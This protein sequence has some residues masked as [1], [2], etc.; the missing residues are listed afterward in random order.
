MSG[1]R[2]QPVL[3]MPNSV[4]V[5]YLYNY[6]DECTKV[7]GG[8][9]IVNGSSCT[10]SKESDH[11]N[12]V[13]ARTTTGYVPEYIHQVGVFRTAEKIT[14]DSNLYSALYLD[15]E[16]NISRWNGYQSYLRVY[17]SKDDSNYP[18]KDAIEL[19][20]IWEGPYKNQRFYR[21][22]ATDEP[23]R[24][25][26]IVFSN[27][28]T[29]QYYVYV[30]HYTDFEE[31]GTCNVYAMWF[32]DSVDPYKTYLY[33][34][35]TNYVELS[36]VILSEKTSSY[37]GYS[38][39]Y[40]TNYIDL[41]I[42]SDEYNTG[43]FTYMNDLIYGMVYANQ[44]YDITP[45]RALKMHYSIPSNEIRDHDGCKPGAT[46]GILSTIPEDA[47][48]NDKI[49][50]QNYD[51][52][53]YDSATYGTSGDGKIL[54]LDISSYTGEYYIGALAGGYDVAATV[55]IYKIWLE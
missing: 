23:I 6:G 50:K 18:G 46:I 13:N 33:D 3:L 51:A 39:T 52:Y 24:S 47:S 43:N 32:G 41:Y 7:T 54:S 11:L 28:P 45:Y 30:V 40:D 29:D 36:D 37:T 31:S 4:K 25:T 38:V 21:L 16:D 5:A 15:F 20:G 8:W 19:G 12:W 53:A 48:S 27:I 34:R 14:F 9:S 55:R 26:P 44:K 35:G 1:R 17:L 22:N 42:H 2:Q 10:L 49:G